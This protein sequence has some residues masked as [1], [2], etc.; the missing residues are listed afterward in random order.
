MPPINSD[1]V[2]DRLVHEAVQVT[3][4]RYLPVINAQR[5]FGLTTE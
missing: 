5:A 4:T 1:S 3:A 2:A